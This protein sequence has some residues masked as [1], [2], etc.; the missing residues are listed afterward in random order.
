MSGFG[1]LVGNGDGAKASTKTGFDTSSTICLSL[2]APMA[3]SWVQGCQTRH[4]ARFCMI[5]TVDNPDMR[6][7]NNC[8]R[9]STRAR[10]RRRARSART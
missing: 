6:A 5:F 3:E 2:S 7:L 8:E 10:L 4:L 9:V 1:H